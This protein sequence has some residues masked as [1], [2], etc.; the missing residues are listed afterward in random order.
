MKPLKRIDFA[1]PQHSLNKLPS[2]HEAYDRDPD[3]EGDADDDESTGSDSLSGSEDEDGN[4]ISGPLNG[5]ANA[6]GSSA[7]GGNGLGK[8]VAHASG[9]G[10]GGGNLLGGS[11]SNKNGAPSSST[12]AAFGRWLCVGIGLQ[13][14]GLGTESGLRCA[15][16][17]ETTLLLG[18]V[19]LAT[20]LMTRAIRTSTTLRVDWASWT[21]QAP[22]TFQPMRMTTSTK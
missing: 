11:N 12:G 1:A 19:P 18:Q 21:T 8:L 6:S 15:D 16:P 14:C 2:V 20:L 3:H 5:E 17:G 7:A 4:G 22:L 13:I 9:A 10:S